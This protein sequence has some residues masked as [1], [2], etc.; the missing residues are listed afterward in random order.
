[1]H[2]FCKA[3]LA[4]GFKDI[5]KEQVQASNDFLEHIAAYGVSFGT[6]EEYM[7][8][9]EIFDAKSVEIEEINSN[10]ENTFTVGHN[11]MSTWTKDEYKKLL[12]YKAPQNVTEV[13]TKI[14]ET[15]G[16]PAAKDWRSLGAVNAVK[17]QAQCGSCWAFSATSAMESAQ[18]I[19]KG[20]ALLSLAE[21]Q[22]VSCDT[23]CYGCQGGW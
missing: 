8:R 6:Q 20:G 19:Q 14:L 4:L 7:F 1:M 2:G 18:F 3:A 16:I 15:E 11:F 13:E 23:Q 17:N 10:P 12:G 21:Q 22:L 9:K 5:C